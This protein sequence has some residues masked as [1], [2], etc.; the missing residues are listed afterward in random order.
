MK[1]IICLCLLLVPLAWSCATAPAKTESQANWEYEKDAI[2]L[3]LTVDKQLNLKDRKPHSLALCVYQLKSPNAFNQLAGDRNGLYQ[4]LQCQVF[5][6]SVAMSKQ[7]F[8]TP[9]KDINTTLD[10][11]EGATYVAMVAGYYGI[12]K[13]KIVRLYK[14]PEITKRKGIL[15]TKT[16][17]PG[18][19]AI[20][21][22]LGALQIQDPT[23]KP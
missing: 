4:L 11:A 2:T 1:R 12:D 19:L 10:R 5:D 7:I 16:V 3:N 23:K 18:K 14:I 20:K 17:K 8:V 9:G 13:D 21:L 22:T 6:P 15:L